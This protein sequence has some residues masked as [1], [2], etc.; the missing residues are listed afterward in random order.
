MSEF[1]QE[2]GTKYSNYTK[3]MVESEVSII[4]RDDDLVWVPISTNNKD[5]R[6]YL[7]WIALGNTASEEVVGE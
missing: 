7:A 2:P 5:Y 3:I 4:R 6:E 1:I